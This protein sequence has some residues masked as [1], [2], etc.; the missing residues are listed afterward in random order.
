MAPVVSVAVCTRNRGV[1]ARHTVEAVLRSA[2]DLDVEYEVLAVD[3]GSTD[4]TGALLGELAAG[5]PRLRVVEEPHPGVS[6]ARNA[7]LAAAAGDIIVFIDDD[8]APEPG[9]LIRLTAPLVSG[10]FDIAAGAVRLAPEVERSWLAPLHL[11]LL[12]STRDG[13][14]DPPRTVVGANWAFR[15][16]A[17]GTRSF[18]VRLGYG[19]LGSME[20]TLLYEQM[21]S[22]GA[23][24]VF[25]ADAVVVHHVNPDRLRP[26][27]LL[28]RAYDQGRGD[29]W[30]HWNWNAGK[31]SIRSYLRWLKVE[32]ELLRKGGRRRLAGELGDLELVRV[33]GHWRGYA[34][35]RWI[36]RDRPLRSRTTVAQAPH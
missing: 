6:R 5:E 14:G 22:A 33:I 4:D 7:A 16:S 20:E 9:W 36:S 19:A 27:A 2:A 35:T 29:G 28:D 23:R 12:A 13:L 17:L 31:Y 34:R 30:M 10:R 11:D 15:R 24:A 32:V 25:V 8:C 21:R 18:D 3:N 26:E 1:R